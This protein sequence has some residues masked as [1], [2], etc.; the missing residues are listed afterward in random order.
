MSTCCN[1][2]LG[3]FY[4]GE[5]TCQLVGIEAPCKEF[6]LSPLKKFPKEIENNTIC[7][8]LKAENGRE[9]GLNFDCIT[10]KFF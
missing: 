10:S 4:I 7:N 1:F 3:I 6:H 5:V 9:V 2:F 8:V